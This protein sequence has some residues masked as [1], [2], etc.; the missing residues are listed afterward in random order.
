MKTSTPS[1]AELFIATGCRLCPVVL[2][3]LSEQL[4]KGELSSLKITNI[5]VDNGRAEELNIRSVPW[6]SLSN[7]NSFMVF[8]GDH[9]PKEIQQ[10]LVTSQTENGMQEY[11][12]E[13]LSNGQLMTIVQAIQI[14]PEIFSHVIAMIKNEETSMDIRIGLDVLIEN[15]SASEILQR[16]SDELKAIASSDNLR[17]KIDAL[18]Y[19]ALTGDIKNKDFLQGKTKDADMQIKEAAIEAIETMDDLINSTM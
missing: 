5:A 17:L 18:H 10:W 13:Y 7:K 8:S 11:I 1:S 4:K 14:N 6:F 3:E 2:K 9:S 16:Y 15:F 12:E 19:I